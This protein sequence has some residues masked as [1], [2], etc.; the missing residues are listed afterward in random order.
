MA[1][2]FISMSGISQ[3]VIF[4]PQNTI[5]CHQ[6]TCVQ[7]MNQS[8]N[9]V[10]S[11]W[12]FGDPTSG[13]NNTSTLMNPMHCF[14]G[15]PATYTIT[16]NCVFSNNSTG[17]ATGTIILTADSATFSWT[18]AG[19]NMVAFT[20]Q[21]GGNPVTWS[22]DFGDATTSTAQNPTHQYATSGNY[23]VHLIIL[24][25]YGC[26]DTTVQN[27]LASPSGI[28][29]SQKNNPFS[30]YPNPSS[31]HLINIELQQ[32]SSAPVEL[33]IENVIGEIVFESKISENGEINL[34]DLK[35]GIYFIRIGNGA[36][37]KIILE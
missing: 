15:G 20:D 25:S 12:N 11:M 28:A 3:N 36:A 2:L 37:K 4:S 1:I 23:N 34:T 24:T 35:S 32:Q 13:A 8:Q 33:K 27:V 21:S 26:I 18:S 16:L 22:W 17:M 19:N 10:S 6:D 31:S 14:R 29:D 5:I 9:V 7:F 30:F